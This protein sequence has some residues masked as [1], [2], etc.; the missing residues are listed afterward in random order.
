M[1]LTDSILGS[2]NTMT[3]LRPSNWWLWLGHKIVAQCQNK[4]VEAQ[5]AQGVRCFDLRVYYDKKMG[6]F[7]FSHGMICYDKRYDIH[8]VIKTINALAHK[9]KSKVYIRL[10]L[11]HCPNDYY[12]IKFI[13]LCKYLVSRKYKYI[14]FIGGNRKGDWKKLY[15]FANNIHDWDISQFVSSMAQDARW[16]E[17]FIPRLYAKRMNK[18]NKHK[19]CNFITLFDFI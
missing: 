16:Y 1:E 5:F 11:E 10:I 14:E 19:T 4:S 18:V 17:K 8:S 7:F 12:S 2:H 15:D 13:S 6:K 9:C 3:Y